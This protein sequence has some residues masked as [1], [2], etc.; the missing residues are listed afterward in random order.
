MSMGSMVVFCV[1]DM[2]EDEEVE[3]EECVVEI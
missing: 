2:I 1:A 3:E